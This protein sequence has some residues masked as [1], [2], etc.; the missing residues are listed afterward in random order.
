MSDNL[1]QLCVN[2]IRT[3]SIDAVQKAK[4]GHPGMPMGMADAAYV[5]W[6][7]FLR[8]NPKDPEWF[9]RDRFILSAGHGS[10]LLYS[11]LYLTGYDLTLED[12]KNFRQWGSKT[13]GHPEYRLTAGVETTTGPL[14]QGLANGVGMAMVEAHLAERFNKPDHIVIDHYTYGIVSDG[15]LMEGISHEAASLA[16]HLKL[17]KIVYLYDDNNISIEGNT[18]LAFTEDVV[19]RFEA[20]GW[21]TQ[22]ID[23]HN[24]EEITKA[25]TEARNVVD[26]PSIIACR[27]HI[28]YGSPHKQDKASSHGAA[29]GEDE[30][31]LTKE[32]LN[33]DPNKFFY[34]PDEVKSFFEEAVPRGREWQSEWRMSIE[35][36]RNVYSD[37]AKKF[38]QYLNKN[39]PDG[40]EQNLPVFKQSDSGMA[41]RKASGSVLNAI[42]DAI[43]NLIGGSADLSPSTKTILENAP[44]FSETKYNGRN[45]HFGVREHAMTAALNGM[46]MHG[47]VIPYGGTFL[48]FSD[49]SRP[50]IRLAALSKI[51]PIF[52]FTHDSIGLGEDGPTH[53]PIEHLMALRAIPGVTVMRPADAN[54][55]TYAWKYALE[56]KG[57]PTALIFTRQNVPVYERNEKNHAK[58]VEKGAYILIDSEKDTPD[59]ILMGTGSEVQIAVETREILAEK[60]IDARVVSMPSWEIFNA[61]DKEYRDLVLPPNV[62][63][64]V[65]VEAGSPQGW[66]K[67]VGCDGRILGINRFGASAPYKKIYQEFGLTAEH[68]ADAAL[69]C[70][71]TEGAAKT[72]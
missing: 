45:F 29:L 60:G 49:Y 40:W 7:K 1:D 43:P 23:G 11:L 18:D 22:R 6:T 39:L 9:D 34:V 67:W 3:L 48:I 69:S 36:Y 2:T 71:K 55:V 50:A 31:A 53:Q 27:T 35:N 13:P 46:V 8:H 63:A 20:Y 56:H 33:W 52:V 16:G 4:C 10:M 47:G 64:R 28:G 30:V 25:I 37:D 24:R 19:K 5:L 32:A 44:S 54:E 42:A 68:M 57:G 65:S 38:D 12:L 41:T 61:Q 14:G 72:S 59:V 26:K 66:E 70:I 21:H 15:D 17:G 51:N 62:K 58:N